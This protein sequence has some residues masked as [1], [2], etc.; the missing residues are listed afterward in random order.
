MRRAMR[1]LQGT[2]TAVE[3]LAWTAGAS[4]DHV[5][6]ARL[7][8]AV[9]QH[10]QAIGG[11]PFGVAPWLGKRQ[12]AE[13]AIRAALGARFIEEYQRGA[14]MDLQEAIVHATG[15]QDPGPAPHRVAAAEPQLTGREAEIAGLVAQGLTNREIAARLV[16]SQRTVESHVENILTKL[17]FARRT[18]I[19]AW[20]SKRAPES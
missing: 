17:G 6:A 7:L 19:A 3:V 13:S 2:A 12:A 4:G 8:G 18:Q 5:R 15:E 1:D 14:E 10:W 9:D 16:I 20:H 11:S